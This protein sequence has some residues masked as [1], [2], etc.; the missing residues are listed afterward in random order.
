MKARLSGT[1]FAYVLAK[2]SL[3]PAL[4]LDCRPFPKFLECAE[5]CIT[6]RSAQKQQHRSA[7]QSSRGSLVNFAVLGACLVFALRAVF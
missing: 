3:Y 2:R 4:L 7:C 5:H 1:V 6:E